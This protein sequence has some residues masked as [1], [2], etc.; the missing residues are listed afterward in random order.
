MSF[1]NRCAVVTGGAQGI[2]RATVKHLLERGAKVAVADAD[3]EAGEEIAQSYAHL[4]EV[5]FVQTDV[6]SESSVKTLVTET[7]ERFGALDYLVNNAGTMIRKSVTELSLDEWNKVIGTNLTGMFLCA[8]YAAP[9]LK[10]SQ[11][12]SGGAIVN[13]A[14]SRA[15]MSE[16]HTESYAASK[17]GVVALTHALS[18]SLG[19]DVRVNCVSPGWIVVDAWKKEAQR[20]EVELRPVDQEQH[21]VGRVG[22]SEDVASL[23]GYLLGDESG[24]ITGQN[25]VIDGGMTRK[26]IYAE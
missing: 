25:F 22:K 16:P 15:V 2:G 11:G 24:F 21:P 19:P 17:G 6:S 7:V 9:H 12:T 26:M 18:I 4:G 20:E 10:E 13:V 3:A 14:S 23:I 1:Q 5:H 8:K